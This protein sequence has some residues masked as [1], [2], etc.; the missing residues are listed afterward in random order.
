MVFLVRMNIF[1]WE[2]RDMM[3]IQEDRIL[4]FKVGFENDVEE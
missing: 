1:H 3:E 2:F 4:M